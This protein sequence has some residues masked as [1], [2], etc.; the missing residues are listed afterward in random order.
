MENPGKLL[1]HYG[2]EVHPGDQRTTEQVVQHYI[3]SGVIS[4]VV[5]SSLNQEENTLY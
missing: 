4:I 3:D 5:D 2:I 1:Q